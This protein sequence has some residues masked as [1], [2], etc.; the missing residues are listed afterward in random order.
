MTAFVYAMERADGAIK[1]G[2]SIQPQQRLSAC[3]GL[4][5]LGLQEMESVP[6]A[7]RREREL[8]SQLAEWALG[9]EWFC[10]SSE[11]VTAAGSLGPASVASPTVGFTAQLPADLVYRARCYA[12]EN[13]TTVQALVSEALATRLQGYVVT[14]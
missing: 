3:G 13:D 6:A 10:P 5:F 8:H 2:H 12:A 1:I 9:G 7:R 4:R 11:V 14:P